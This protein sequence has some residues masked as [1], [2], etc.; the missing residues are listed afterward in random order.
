M[1]RQ[2]RGFSLAP[3]YFY[4]Q[5]FLKILPKKKAVIYKRSSHERMQSRG[6]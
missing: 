3:A 2:G 5:A 6:K 1:I 4:L